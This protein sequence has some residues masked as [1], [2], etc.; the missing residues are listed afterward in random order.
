MKIRGETIRGQDSSRTCHFADYG[1]WTIRGKTDKWN[2][3]RTNCLKSPLYLLP[4]RE[5]RSL[6]RSNR[7][8][9]SNYWQITDSRLE[10]LRHNVWC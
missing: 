1:V 5:Q 2:Y 7:R 8:R 3:S 4:I 9:L 10:E 6:S